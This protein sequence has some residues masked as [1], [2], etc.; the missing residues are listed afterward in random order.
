PPAATPES[1]RGIRRSP[2]NVQPVF[3]A[4]GETGHSLFACKGT[5]VLLRRDN[6]LFV[7]STTYA[8]R[9]VANRL[10]PI[11]PSK[12]FP[13]QALI[14]KRVHHLP[15]WSKVDLPEHEKWI[16]EKLGIAATLMVPLLR[17]DEALGVL[18][19]LRGEAVAFSDTEIELAR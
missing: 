4:I 7:T 15:D 2:E 12:N 17:G 18:T 14:E 19:F 5:S 16:Q 9:P 8:S 6:D 3:E 11:D 13:S 1:L 10:I